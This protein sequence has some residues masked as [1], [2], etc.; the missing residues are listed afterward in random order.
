MNITLQIAI[1]AKVKCITLMQKLNH[2]NPEIQAMI[3]EI[4]HEIKLA[5]NI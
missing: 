5:G 4:G 3:R 2:K 1:E